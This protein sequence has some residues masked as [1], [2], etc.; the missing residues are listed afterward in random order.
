[1]V[2][3][4]NKRKSSGLFSRRGR[5]DILLY[6]ILRKMDRMSALLR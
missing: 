3:K 6:T 2:F 5:V 4:Y 1:M